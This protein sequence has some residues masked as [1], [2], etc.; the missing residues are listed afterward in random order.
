MKGEMTSFD[1]MSFVGEAQ[2]LVGGYIDK[3]YNPSREK[4]HIRVNL[5]QSHKEVITACIGKWI[6]IQESIEPPVETLS[7]GMFLRKHLLNGRIGRVVQHNFDRVVEIHISKKEELRLVFEMFGKGNLLLVR[8]TTIVSPLYTRSWSTRELRAGCPYIY[9]PERINLLTLEDKDI[10]N[11]LASSDSPIVHTL[12]MDLSL[13]GQYAEELC[14]R[15]HLRKDKDAKDLNQEEVDRLIAEM[16]KV[17]REVKEGKEFFVFI[18]DDVPVDFAPISLRTLEKLDQ[19]TFP[20]LSKA[21]SYFLS[22]VVTLESDE[23]KEMRKIERRI[24]QQ[25][26]AIQVLQEEAENLHNLAEYLYEDYQFVESIMR[27]IRQGETPQDIQILSKDPARK[28]V[29]LKLPKGY[30]LPLNYEKSVIQNAQILYEKEKSARKKIEGLR[31]ALAESERKLG[32]AR[33]THIKKEFK[34]APT[35]RFWFESYRWFISSEGN[36]VMGGRDAKSNDRLVKRH[37]K[38]GDRYVHA[39]IRGAPSV[40][41]KE[42]SK[43][44]EKTLEEACQFALC[45]SKAWKLGLAS[46]SA[47]WVKPEQV[48]KSPQTGE[49]LKKGAFVIRGK[50]NYFHKLKI[51]VAVGEITHEGARKVMCGPQRS[52]A[53]HSEDYLLLVPG[54]LG[55]NELSKDLSNAFLVPIEEILRILPQGSFKILRKAGLLS[56]AKA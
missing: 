36:L 42:G 50:R 53:A 19:K 52:V 2:R 9:P 55:R 6:Y 12:A 15:A 48:S 40:I 1:I 13:G 47:Y 43:C 31:K 4:I 29:N 37:L 38:E 18:Q 51:E 46:G 5:P 49:Y 44:T 14:A 27:S 16:R 39:D 25:K 28:I 8:D 17:V 45:F 21:I 7:F 3:I 54:K 20:S 34:T 30:E 26:D 11:V 22:K 41:V 32:M 33:E 10:H 35:K 24:K 23:E 56:K